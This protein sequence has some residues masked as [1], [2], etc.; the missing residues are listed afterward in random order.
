[1]IRWVEYTYA[2]TYVTSA[3]IGSYRAWI[4]RVD[5]GWCV[6]LT[7]IHRSEHTLTSDVFHSL[8]AAKERAEIL[9][10]MES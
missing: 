3:T 7:H 10:L 2:G 8:P 9:L 6:E 5:D 4:K 1:M